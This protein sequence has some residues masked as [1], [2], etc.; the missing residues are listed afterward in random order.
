MTSVLFNGY[1]VELRKAVGLYYPPKNKAEYLRNRPELSF[2]RPKT[3]GG[4]REKFIQLDFP[5]FRW[6]GKLPANKKVTISEIE[7]GGI[8]SS[9]LKL[10]DGTKISG[11]LEECS[12]AEKAMAEA[13]INRAQ[14]K[15]ATQAESAGLQEIVRE[16]LAEQ[17]RQGNI[18][19]ALTEETHKANKMQ[20][21]AVRNAME[22]QGVRGTAPKTRLRRRENRRTGKKHT[23]NG[24]EKYVISEICRKTMFQRREKG[25]QALTNSEVIELVVNQIS[26]DHKLKNKVL[27]A[28]RTWQLWM[29]KYI[30]KSRLIPG[31]HP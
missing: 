22:F 19:K 21:G 27:P 12:E 16:V 11:R 10:P 7:E 24:Q 17:K 13:R 15:R 2:P 28:K 4:T 25:E 29:E 1:L 26:R 9:T 8:E 5:T 31:A 6:T 23:L 3:Q 14:K 30:R 18:L 20:T